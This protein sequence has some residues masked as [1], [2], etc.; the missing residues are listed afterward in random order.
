[1]A[2]K[3]AK[4]NPAAE[5]RKLLETGKVVI[6]ADRV[7]KLLRQGK[8][9]KVLVTSNCP[10]EKKQDIMHYARTSKAEFVQLEME[11]DE[12]GVACKKQFA[13]SVIGLLKE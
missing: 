6:G 13:I 8:L 7:E 4:I 2:K 9:A 12:L 10:D 1:M 5:V 11:N 3:T